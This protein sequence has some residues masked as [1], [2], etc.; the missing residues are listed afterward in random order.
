MGTI[1]ISAF[2]KEK[3]KHGN[4]LDHTAYV[5][6]TIWPAGTF[7]KTAL[8]QEITQALKSHNSPM[9]D[10]RSWELIKESALQMCAYS[11]DWI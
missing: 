5:L 1:V 3:N 7:E 2:V 8:Y 4:K 9:H 11:I 10:I 6:L